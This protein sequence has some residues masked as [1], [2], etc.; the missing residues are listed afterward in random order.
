[1]IDRKK[2]KGFA[3]TLV[4][5]LIVIVIIAVLAAI[6]LPKFMDSGQRSKEASLKGDL[7]LLRN[8]VELFHTDTGAYPAA[9]TDLADIAAPA[10]GK[11]PQGNSYS[12]NGPDWHGPYVRVVPN[13]P[14]SGA[15]FT[16]STTSP[17]VGNV[18]S[19]ASGD[20]LDGTAYNTW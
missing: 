8:A 17:T 1:M 7:K 2:R 20:G 11:D 10:A 12:I 16:Y 6:A 4:E 18:T 5:L 13:D 19:S 3:F 15:A 9:V 14:I